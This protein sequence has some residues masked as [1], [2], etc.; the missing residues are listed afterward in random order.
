MMEGIVGLDIETTHL[1]GNMGHILCACAQPLGGKPVVWQI[2]K[3]KSWNPTNPKSYVNDKVMVKEIVSYVEENAD[4]LITHY[5]TKFD[6]PF[7]N[8]RALHWDINPLPPVAHIDLWKVSRVNLRLTSNRQA[9]INDL[10]Q[11]P[12]SKYKPGWEVWR[13]A[14]Y[15]SSKALKTLTDYCKN[16]VAGLLENYVRMRPLIKHHPYAF[17]TT[18]GKH[19][20]PVCM[21]KNTQYRGWRRTKLF[22]IERVHCQ[23]CSTWFDGKREKV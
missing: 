11:A 4:I 8:T 20:C 17:T 6:L 5:G 22:R 15:G 2:N 21:S 12:H 16:D 7:I 14:Q 13:A 19:A 10:I 23:E 18:T 1:A 9:T 3:Q